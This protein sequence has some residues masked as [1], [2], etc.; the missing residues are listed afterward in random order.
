MPALRTFMSALVTYIKAGY[1]S[2]PDVLADFG[3]QTPKAR[4]QLTVE[5]KAAA[6]AKRAAT[7]AARNTMGSKQKKG[8]KGNVVGVTVTPVTAPP[9]IVKADASG[10]SSPSGPSA[11]TNTVPVATTPTAAN[12]ATPQHAT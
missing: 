8:V 12:T 9:P 7:R 2:Q 3:I 1:G 4:A 11:G 5:A 10:S 6:S